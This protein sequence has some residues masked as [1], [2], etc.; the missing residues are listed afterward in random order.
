MSFTAELSCI[1]NHAISKVHLSTTKAS[2]SQLL[3]SSFLALKPNDFDLQVKNA[4]IKFSALLAEHNVAFQFIDHL[5]ELMKSCF[6]DS[7]ICQ[8][9]KLR[10]TKATN[11]VK[12]VIAHAQKHVLFK[13]INIFKF[14]IMVDDS[15]DI[16]TQSH[17]CIV[18]RF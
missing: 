13:K 10:R 7:K 17:I 16:A 18:V 1:K 15:T 4:E 8:S 6:T 14:S 9:M 12:N 11:I 3:L 5:E 2:N